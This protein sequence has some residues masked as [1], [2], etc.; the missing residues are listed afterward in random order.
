M[1]VRGDPP[2]TKYNFVIRALSKLAL[3]P[4]EITDFSGMQFNIARGCPRG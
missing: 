2:T 1:R 3:V 4:W